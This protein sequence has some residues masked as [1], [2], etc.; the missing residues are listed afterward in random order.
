[1]SNDRRDWPVA[2][3]VATFPIHRVASQGMVT[4]EGVRDF[5]PDVRWVIAQVVADV[6]FKLL[7]E[8]I[9]HDM[10]V[11]NPRVDIIVRGTAA[12]ISAEAGLAGHSL[13]PDLRYVQVHVNPNA[14][15]ENW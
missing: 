6:K 12:C 13:P 5:G 11:F 10:D 3:E 15:W 14:P 4:W 8:A 2:P 9:K 7:Q 1:M